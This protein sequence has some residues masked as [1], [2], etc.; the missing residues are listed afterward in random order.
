MFFL[1]QHTTVKTTGHT[2]ASSSRK[3][4]PSTNPGTDVHT[5]GLRLV[6]NIKTCSWCDLIT[7]CIHSIPHY[8]LYSLFLISPEIVAIELKESFS[9]DQ[10]HVVKR[11][12]DDAKNS[13]FGSLEPP[14]VMTGRTR[15][16]KTRNIRARL[17]NMTLKIYRNR[18]V[19]LFGPL[20]TLISRANSITVKTVRG[21]VSSRP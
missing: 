16:C 12:E 2:T 7:Y 15:T 20:S 3:G 13:R 17:S 18:T 21:T 5:P 6:F 19:A 11:R 9:H 8:L 4:A 14:A 1:V 10:R